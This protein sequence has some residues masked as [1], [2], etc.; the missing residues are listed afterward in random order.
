[1]I[2]IDPESITRTLQSLVSIDS[3]NPDLDASG[4]GEAAIAAAVA[5]TL[6]GLG[7]AVELIEH[8]PGRSSVIGT[9]R[10]SGGGRSLMLNAHLDTV[11][12]HGMD[13]PFSARIEN[14]RLYGR[15]SFDMKGSLAACIGA[16]EALVRG[17]ARLAGDLVVTA[18]ADEEVASFG[19]QTVLERCRTDGAVVTEPTSRRLCMAHKGFVWYEITTIGRAAHGSRPDLGIDANV[20]MGRVLVALERLQAQLAGGPVHALV[21]APSVHAATLHGGTGLSTYAAECRLGV[22]RRTIPGEPEAAATAQLEAL[23]DELRAADPG[24]EARL[25]VSLARPPFEARPDSALARSLGGAAETVLGSAPERVGETAWM[26][27]AFAAAAGIDTI[28]FGPHGE[29]AHA[30]VEWVDLA[31]VFEVADVLARTAL[32]YCRPT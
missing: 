12:V 4:A 26:D 18:V 9:L 8:R 3:I 15:G 24:F 13:D 27:A 28:V 14:G 7:L 32:D 31:S 30:A 1:M 17:G 11:G 16:V 5:T 29:G 6:D 10:G 20:R 19:M 23:L 22:E 2:R 21:G 25:S